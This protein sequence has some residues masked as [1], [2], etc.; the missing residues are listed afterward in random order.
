MARVLE[1]HSVRNVP[2]Y[3]FIILIIIY[4]D[5]KTRRHAVTSTT[6]QLTINNNGITQFII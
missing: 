5:L 1:F 2:M 6:Y 3:L 4:N